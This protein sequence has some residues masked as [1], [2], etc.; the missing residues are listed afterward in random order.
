VILERLGNIKRTTEQNPSPLAA[1]ELWE[2]AP[3]N[4]WWDFLRRNPLGEKQSKTSSKHDLERLYVLCQ[5]LYP[6]NGISLPD[7]FERQDL[8]RHVPNNGPTPRGYVEWTTE[9]GISRN[10]E[11]YC[12]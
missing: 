2:E 11:E 8:H 12:Q 10:R 5:R 7:D 9:A 1:G 6:D 3:I 4:K